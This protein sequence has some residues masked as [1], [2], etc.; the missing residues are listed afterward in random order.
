MHSR[1]RDFVR[2]KRSPKI[3][4]RNC[5]IRR[6]SVERSR[7]PKVAVPRRT[8]V[9]SALTR[10]LARAPVPAGLPVLARRPVPVRAIATDPSMALAR[11]PIQGSI[12]STSG[13]R[14]GRG[15][16]LSCCQARPA[17][18]SS[19]G[20]RGRRGPIV[21]VGASNGEVQVRVDPSVPF[22]VLS[23]QVGKGRYS[24]C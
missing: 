15:P 22:R 6:P 14:G 18:A 21:Q 24:F 3:K 23:F 11:G 8:R 9:T 10:G 17:K 2:G 1:R 20:G 16:T 4:K 13:E 12:A 19:E 5:R 7:G